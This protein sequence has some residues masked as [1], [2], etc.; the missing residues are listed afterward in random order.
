MGFL[1]S[2]F[3]N[4]TFPDRWIGGDW[5]TPWPLRSPDYTPLDFFSFGDQ[6]QILCHTNC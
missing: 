2:D 1:V 6:G 5:P 3:L 4:E